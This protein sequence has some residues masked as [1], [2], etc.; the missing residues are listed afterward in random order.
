MKTLK[1]Q[2]LNLVDLQNI[3]NKI[4][5]IKKENITLEN[6]MLKLEN[7]IKPKLDELEAQKNELKSKEVENMKLQLE[8]KEKEEYLKSLQEKFYKVRSPKE[9]N[10]ID[11]EITNTKKFIGEL[12]EKGIKLL[13]EIEKLKNALKE[14]E[15]IISEELKNL[16]ETKAETESK[17]RENEKA[18]NE[19]LAQREEITKNISSE[20]LKDYEYIASKKNGIGIAA[21]KNGICTGCYMSI[22]PQTVH[23][24]RKY[25]K[26]YHC[27]NCS[28]ILYYPD[29][30]Q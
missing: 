18:L 22:P 26:I 7:E 24:I 9:L 3:D 29:W 15:Q 28:R 20:I 11:I 25:I 1:E 13:D 16:N 27:Q 10:A 8:L 30:D 12:E 6:E 4:N 21:V 17:K 2:L 19:L 14:N 23:D 5:K